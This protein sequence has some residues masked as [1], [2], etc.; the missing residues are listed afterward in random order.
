MVS[1]IVTT[2]PAAPNH[3][4]SLPGFGVFGTLSSATDNYDNA[5]SLHLRRARPRRADPDGPRRVRQRAR[6]G[7][8]S[9]ARRGAGLLA[10]GPRRRSAGAFA[11]IPGL[12]IRR[13]ENGLLAADGSLFEIVADFERRAILEKLEI[14]DWSQTTTAEAL[15]V[16]PSALNQEIKRLN[17]EI[18]KRGS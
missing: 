7:E 17:I 12:R 15:R 11:R 16:Q 14:C 8:R 13:N 2:E 3:A 6:T 1:A 18:R 10:F 9:R 4:P 5:L